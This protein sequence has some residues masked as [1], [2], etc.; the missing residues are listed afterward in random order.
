VGV[1]FQE[2]VQWVES[3]DAIVVSDGSYKE[4]MGTSSWR[5]LSKHDETKIIPGAKFVP[6]RSQHQSSYR[7][8]LAGIV[9]IIVFISLAVEF[10]EVDQ[11]IMQM[12]CNGIEALCEISE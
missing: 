7:S 6:G 2:L 9:S 1:E 11:V 8:E 4:K 3:G 10:Y 12:V 5:I